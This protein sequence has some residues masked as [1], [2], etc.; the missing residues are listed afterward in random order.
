MSVHRL[1][2]RLPAGYDDQT[3]VEAASREG[4]IT[5]AL[6]AHYAQGEIQN[7]LL[8]GFCGFTEAEIEVHISIIDKIIR[9]K[10]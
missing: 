7:G 3:I 4:V 9:R 1:I 8:L 2:E 6:S 5:S 10:Y